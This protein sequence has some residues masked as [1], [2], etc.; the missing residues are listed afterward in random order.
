MEAISLIDTGAEVSVIDYKFCIDNPEVNYYRGNS[1]T[2]WLAGLGGNRVQ[3]CGEYYGPLVLDENIP[4]RNFSLLIVKDLSVPI[5]LGMDF[6]SSSKITLDFANNVLTSKNGNKIPICLKES[7][8]KST[9]LYIAQKLVLAPREHKLVALKARKKIN[10][11]GCVIPLQNE[12]C[13]SLKVA[14]NVCKENNNIVWGD[15]ANLTDK[16]L[17]VEETERIALWQP[18]CPVLM[19]K[20]EPK[21]CED[22]NLEEKLGI[23]S[24]NLSAGQKLAV[25]G[26]LH[27]FKDLFANKDDPLGYCETIKHKIDVGDSRPIKQRFRRLRP[28]L[29]EKVE[30]EIDR[31]EEL[32]LI[33]KS[34]SPWAS[35]L[36]PVVKRD[37]R[38]RICIDYRKVNAVTKKDSYPLPHIEDA[39]SQFEGARYFSTLDL[40]SGYH[41]IALEEQSKEVTAFCTEKGL[42]QYR[43]MPQG[44]CGSPASFQRLMNI[45]F[46]GM[47]SNKAMAYLDDLVIMGRTFEEHLVNLREVL[48]RLRAHG[49]KL[50]VDK[51]KLFQ[52]EVVYLGHRLSK[53]GIRPS[54]HNVDALIN[55]PTPR[56]IK[57]VRGL[58]GL[59]NY[60]GRFIKDVASIM[61]P[62]YE[63]LSQRKIDWT[64]QCQEAFD[65]IKGILTSYPVLSFPRYGPTDTFILT[66]DGSG[67]GMGAVLS[68]IQD[69]VERPLGFASRNFCKAQNKNPATERE[70]C[71]LRFGVKHFRPYLYGRD[72]KVRTDHQAL[73]YLQQMKLV[74]NRLLRTYEDL[75]I[76]NFTIEYIRGKDN[77]VADYLSRS[78]QLT[79]ENEVSDDENPELID[80]SCSEPI[81]IVPGGCNS[82]FEALFFAMKPGKISSADEL[83]YEVVNYL[84]Q[85]IT[86]YGYSNKS[87]DRKSIEALNQKGTFCGMNLLQP[88]C[89]I[90]NLN[91]FVEL[92]PGP[93][94]EVLSKFGGKSQIKLQCL[95]GIHFNVNS[96]EEDI[97]NE[98][99]SKKAPVI[100]HYLLDDTDIEPLAVLN[101]PPNVEEGKDSTEN[102]LLIPNLS[103]I[104]SPEPPS[105]CKME[106]ESIK[107]RIHE[108]HCAIGHVG[109][110]KTYRICEKELPPTKGLY[111]LVKEVLRQCERCQR[112]KPFI[113][114]SNQKFPMYHRKAKCAGDIIA[115]DIFDVTTRSK[116]GFCAMLTGIDVYSKFAWAVPVKNKQSKTIVRALEENILKSCVNF[117]STLLTDNGPEFVAK[118]FRELVNKYQLNHERSIPYRPQSNGAVERLNRTIKERLAIALNGYYS[119]WDLEIAQI[120]IQYNRMVHEET[121]RTPVSYY[122]GKI[123]EPILPLPKKEFKSAGKN[124]KPYKRG[125]LVLYR[126]PFHSKDQRHKLAPRF[127]GPYEIIECI[128]A[129]T[130]KLKDVNSPRKR[131][132][133]HVSQLRPYHHSDRVIYNSKYEN[134]KDV[135][136]TKSNISKATEEVTPLV[137]YERPVMTRAELEDC[138][139]I[140]SPAKRRTNNRMLAS[141]PE[142]G[143]PPSIG[144]TEQNLTSIS[145]Q[146]I[147]FLHVPGR[148]SDLQQPANEV[149]E[150]TEGASMQAM[151]P[152]QG[153]SLSPP[154]GKQPVGEASVEVCHLFE[155]KAD[156]NKS[157]SGF[158]KTGI[159]EQNFNKLFESKLEE[160]KD[161]SGFD[162][163]DINKP[164]KNVLE[165]QFDFSGFIPSESF[166]TGQ[167]GAIRSITHGQEAGQLVRDITQLALNCRKLLTRRNINLRNRKTESLTNVPR[168]GSNPPTI[169]EIRDLIRDCKAK[170]VDCQS[171]DDSRA[172]EIRE[173]VLQESEKMEES[174]LT[175]STLEKIDSE[176]EEELVE[177]KRQ[178]FM[179]YVNLSSFVDHGVLLLESRDPSICS[180]DELTNKLTAISFPY[181]IPP[182][183]FLDDWNW[184]F[185]DAGLSRSNSRDSIDKNLDLREELDSKVEAVVLNQNTSST[186]INYEAER[187]LV[188]LECLPLTDRPCSEFLK[189][190]SDS[191]IGETIHSPRRK[192]KRFNGC[193]NT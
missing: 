105:D 1:S 8:Y 25:N 87:A 70:L 162:E 186:E 78:P 164:V 50:S 10:G 168:A 29:K 123:E 156:D 48:D 55:L 122:T 12:H 185:S 147:P 11:E 128:S 89:D 134:L 131:I 53:D 124:F 83:R 174:M 27:E 21:E 109:Q 34:V 14:V 3:V 192:R 67:D 98:E 153:G 60:Y 112:Y 61:K 145:P 111:R 76:G 113:R 9:I 126:I 84:L 132:L 59:V 140:Y 148:E 139:K 142:G 44:A 68:Q 93:V 95:G 135:K 18:V 129:V 4:S 187:N 179:L 85:N 97:V 26:V 47:P 90:Y 165:D 65:K 115:L 188:G 100:L 178:I 125:E 57:Q 19:N 77:C 189:G 32:G 180:D 24:L 58:C 160:N 63:L 86:K 155:S 33:E 42:Y 116:N 6:L 127:K 137:F 79:N 73:V 169:G 152:E 171:D 99:T 91:V 108:I 119:E 107:D 184:E 16:D 72:Y 17:V 170:V 175:I 31:M 106:I 38:V 56:T 30:A 110:T 92:S 143:E 154:S 75:N 7:S 181:V 54:K 94:V 71:A 37:G 104:A 23:E 2:K 103:Q 22:T 151:G 36:V 102:R 161:F 172:S 15:L 35:P 13:A 191:E 118:P 136:A 46:H 43:V 69:G 114:T 40:L 159:D 41:Q 28:P 82:L 80:K 62:I 96:M 158:G 117:P 66:T 182:S 141:T 101:P 163:G 39:L 176:L 130:Y 51:C 146:S 20:L 133:A 45:I 193:C 183:T 173:L 167:S 157:F 120:I 150:Q 138:M 64:E 190:S 121:G 49:L 52:E 144:L 81:H 149:G 74:D 177:F 5:I 88:F 166:Q